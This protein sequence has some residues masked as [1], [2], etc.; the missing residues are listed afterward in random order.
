M[1]LRRRGVEVGL[2][3]EERDVVLAGLYELWLIRSAFD[4]EPTGDAIPFAR[5]IRHDTIFSL[6]AKLG[7][8]RD[9]VMFGAFHDATEEVP[10]VPEYAADETDE[11]D[12]G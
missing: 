12:E 6:V 10:P 3:G 9:E 5:D 1:R 8:D 4:N 7:G 11:T 2:T